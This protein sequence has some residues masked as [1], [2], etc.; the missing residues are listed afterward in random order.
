MSY[1]FNMINKM[2]G[3]E[4]CVCFTK[5]EIWRM[6]DKIKLIKQKLHKHFKEN[7]DI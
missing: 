3:V 6:R 2:G 4:A 7:E 1:A 5:L